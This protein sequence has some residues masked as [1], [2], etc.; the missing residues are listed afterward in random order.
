MDTSV[1]LLSAKTVKC[2]HIHAERVNAIRVAIYIV[3][4]KMTVIMVSATTVKML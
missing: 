2:I 1:D 3:S 4:K